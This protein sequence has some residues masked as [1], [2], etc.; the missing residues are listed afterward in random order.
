MGSVGAESISD[1]LSV[2]TETGDI[3][4][5]LWYLALTDWLFA[6]FV[7]LVLMALA[8][9]K[10]AIYWKESSGFKGFTLI[11]V[12]IRDQGIYYLLVIACC[13]LNT[14][15]PFVISQKPILD[16]ILVGL[17][18]PTFLSV[19]GSRLLF[20]LKEAG[21]YGVNI[22]TNYRSNTLSQLQFAGEHPPESEPYT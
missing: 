12:A 18:N 19:L 11:R 2:C 8:L 6:M 1:T 17:G 15:G 9:Y 16:V 7:G 14:T 5:N 21:E 4:E 22:G 10:A 3:E 13:I 20:N